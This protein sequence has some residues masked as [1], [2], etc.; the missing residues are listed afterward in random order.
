MVLGVIQLSVIFAQNYWKRSSVF[1]LPKEVE[2][3]D[4]IG[5]SLYAPCVWSREEGKQV[6]SKVER[7]V[8]METLEEDKYIL[9]RLIQRET[10]NNIEK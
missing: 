7:P 8:K 10:A 3:D 1:V 4:E 5:R 2:L 9:R 6:L